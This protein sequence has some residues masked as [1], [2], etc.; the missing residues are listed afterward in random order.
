[1]KEN[2]KKDCDAEKE[3]TTMLTEENMLV[4]GAV[5]YRTEKAIT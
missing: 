3:H 4:N 2:G 5:M 1:M